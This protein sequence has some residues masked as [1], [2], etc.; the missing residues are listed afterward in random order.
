MIAQILF[1]SI[2]QCTALQISVH[3]GTVD[4][5]EIFGSHYGIVFH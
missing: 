2:L 1:D 5:K 4:S 3:R